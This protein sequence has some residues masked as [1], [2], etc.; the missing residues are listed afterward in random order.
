MFPNKVISISES[1]IWKLTYILETL[2]EKDYSIEKLW[3]QVSTKFE[4]INQF[5]I[6][7]DILFILHKIEYNENIGGISIC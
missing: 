6:G 3:G 4:D 1:I 7:L 5:I 2:N